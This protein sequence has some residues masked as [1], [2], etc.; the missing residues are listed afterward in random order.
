MLYRELTKYPKPLL[1]PQLLTPTGSKN[2]AEDKTSIINHASS[3]LQRQSRHKGFK[4]LGKRPRD[5]Y[6]HVTATLLTITHV[7][8]FCLREATVSRTPPLKLFCQPFSGERS[9]LTPWTLYQVLL[10]LLG[11]LKI[12]QRRL[13][14]KRVICMYAQ[15]RMQNYVTFYCSL[16]THIH[17]CVYVYMRMQTKTYILPIHI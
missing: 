14:W 1:I 6:T 2:L 5:G 8:I 13:A 4:S 11:I 17:I 15:I 3:Y 12:L 7:S 16:T 10:K 9:C